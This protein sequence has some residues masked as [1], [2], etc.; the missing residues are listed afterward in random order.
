MYGIKMIHVTSYVVMLSSCFTTLGLFVL[1][2]ESDPI[3]KLSQSTNQA[4]R[5][6]VQC[7]LFVLYLT[8]K[9]WF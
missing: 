3:I 6:K 8:L 4:E 9:C 7:L 1:S 2:N 5:E